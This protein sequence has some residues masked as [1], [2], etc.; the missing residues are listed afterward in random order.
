MSPI[1]LRKVLYGSSVQICV[2]QPDIIRNHRG[3]ALPCILSD[4]CSTTPSGSKVEDEIK[5]KLKGVDSCERL[6]FR[7]RV[8]KNRDDGVC[9]VEYIP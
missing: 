2:F 8:L 6:T 3:L 5:A 7:I 1:S 9:V 4:P